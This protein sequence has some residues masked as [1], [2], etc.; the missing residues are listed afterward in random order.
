MNDIVFFDV[1]ARGGVVELSTLARDVLVFAFE[2]NPKEFARLVASERQR[3]KYKQFKCFE[4]ALSDVC[5]RMPFYITDN[6]SYGSLLAFDE[7]GFKMHQR[8]MP[9]YSLWVNNF[10]VK[11]TVMAE[12]LTLD[13][14]CEQQSVRHIDYLKLDTQ[15]AELRILKGGSATLAAVGVIKCEVSFTPVYEGQAFFS[16]IDLFLRSIGFAFVDCIFYPDVL[17]QPGFTAMHDR[18][19]FTGGADAIYVNTQYSHSDA[20]Y[21][22]GLLL[23]SL[24]YRSE[25]LH[26]IERHRRL[27]PDEALRLVRRVSGREFGRR[28]LDIS[29]R[30][31]PPAVAGM[32]RMIFRR[33]SF[34]R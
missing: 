3:K 31:L 25:A 26:L 21:R 33:R 29:K 8:L 13:R 5:G 11:Q 19:R 14:F 27:H 30:W 22:A 17:S 10:R 1:G 34:P 16:E 4:M 15:G 24:G 32:L 20:G 2:P 23:A 9:A 7:T 6:P 28:A 18:P 12:T